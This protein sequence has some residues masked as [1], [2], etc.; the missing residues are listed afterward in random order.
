MN[1]T[2]NNGFEFIDFIYTNEE[3]LHQFNP[4]AGSFALI[5]CEGKYLLCYNT[6]RKQWEIP[7]GKCEGNETPK[8]C[9]IRELYEETGQQVQDLAF[10]GLAKVKNLSDGKIKYNPVY[11][12]T[13]EELESFLQN[14][15]TSEIKLWDLKEPLGPIDAVDIRIFDFIE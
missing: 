12:T 4:L 3:E 1:I 6:W 5:K 8:E 14:N 2:K 7:A 9:A 10:Q 11:T 13:I 15:E